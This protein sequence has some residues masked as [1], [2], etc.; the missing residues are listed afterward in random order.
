MSDPAV[1][2][3]TRALIDRFYEAYVTG[4]LAGMLALLD[5]DAVVT[6]NGH[7]VFRGRAEY[8]PYLEWAGT[9]LPELHFDVTAKIVDGDR[10]AV[11]WDERGT[12]A[13]GE[14]WAAI[15]VDAYRVA[16]DRIVAVTV[17]SDTDKMRRLLDRYP[18]GQGTGIGD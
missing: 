6:F 1:T 10:A 14:P 17:Y 15:G 5:E 7:G 18:G 8:Q 12:T 11:T 2:A 3:A 13:R 16:G 9:Q 4:N